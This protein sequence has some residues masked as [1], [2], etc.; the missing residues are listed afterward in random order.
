M[1]GLFTPNEYRKDF[2]YIDIEKLKKLH[3]KLIICDIDNTLVAHDEKLPSLAAKSFVARVKA[4][5]L[6]ICLISNNHKER[7]E[8]FA[9][10][11]SLR[12]YSFAK[13]PLSYTYRKILNDYQIDP[14]AVVA[15]GDQLLTDVLGAKRMRIYVILTHPLVERDLQSTKLNRKLEHRIYKH[16]EKKK[17]L[18]KGVFDE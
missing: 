15:I 9:K 18:K 5:G 6:D 14:S 3:K 4:Q 10:A 8:V 11:L 7:V 16:M 13:K 12:C 17:I 2:T 1:I